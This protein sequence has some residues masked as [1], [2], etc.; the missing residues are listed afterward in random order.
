MFEEAFKDFELSENYQ[1]KENEEIKNG[2]LFCKICGKQ[3][4]WNA[5]NG[6]KYICICDCRKKELD[7]QEQEIL[8]QKRF[9]RFITLQKNSLLGERFKSESFENLNLERPK[10][11][12][13]ALNVSKSFVENWNKLKDKSC[14]IF[15][16]GDCG[17]GKTELTV[18]VGNALMQQM[19]R[20]IF[21]SF[22]EILKQ[23]L[24]NFKDNEIGQAEFIGNLV[25]CDL[26]V[27]DDLG[28]ENLSDWAKSK[29][30]DVINGRYNSNKP[31]L[32][33][34]N[35]SL[36]ELEQKGY[37]EK[38]LERI[39]EMTTYKLELRGGSFRKIKKE[40]K[41]F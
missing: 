14:G 1:L 19:V 9:E 41:L 40:E 6:K 4:S 2:E 36:S 30:Y 38:V 23:L 28:S 35:Y 13:N 34:S 21:T 3:K 25:N 26:L 20:V 10:D 16:Y 15:Y 24:Q 32:F 22:V 7:L 5:P 11:F 8:K 37:E 31:T 17:T 18:C 33:S 12:L 29:I 39:A 27:L